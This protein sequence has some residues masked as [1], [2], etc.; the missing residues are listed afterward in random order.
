MPHIYV[1]PPPPPTTNPDPERKRYAKSPLEQRNRPRRQFTGAARSH[2]SD[3][4]FSGDR[5]EKRK[6]RKKDYKVVHP[7][8]EMT[9]GL[10]SAVALHIRME[11]G[12]GFKWRH[13]GRCSAFTTH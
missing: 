1:R 13:S 6:G 7:I 11:A 9:E 5:P 3:M 8:V 10:S 2:F 12:T 4:R